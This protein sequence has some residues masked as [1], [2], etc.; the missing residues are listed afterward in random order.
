MDE[1]KCFHVPDIASSKP[2]ARNERE[3]TIFGF[4]PIPAKLWK[5]REPNQQC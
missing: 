5:T 1:L 4:N 3:L 2:I